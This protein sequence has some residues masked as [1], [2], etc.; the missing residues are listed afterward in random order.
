MTPEAGATVSDLPNGAIA[1]DAGES[2]VY[3]DGSA[4]YEQLNGQYH[5]IVPPTGIT[6]PVPPVGS[7]QVEMGGTVYYKQGD[8]YYQPVSENGMT[9]Y[10]TAQI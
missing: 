3:Y 6:V 2:T 4:F 8:M 9:V 5:A 1:I 7:T 10:R